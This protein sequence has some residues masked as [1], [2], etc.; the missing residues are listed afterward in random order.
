MSVEQIISSCRLPG[1][2]TD[3]TRGK[4]VS[5]RGTVE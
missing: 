1:F 3:R 5:V 4:D 2:G